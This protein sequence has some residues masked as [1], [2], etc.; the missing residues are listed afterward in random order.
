MTLQ[1]K[2][3]TTV[4]TPRSRR[5][6]FL[7]LP[8]EIR[9]LILEEVIKSAVDDANTEGPLYRMC[10]AT[11]FR[12]DCNGMMEFIRDLLW[13]LFKLR[14]L[15]PSLPE[16]RVEY[17]KA[18]Q[19]VSKQ[20]DLTETMLLRGEA[21]STSISN[22]LTPYLLINWQLNREVQAVVARSFPNGRFLEAHCCCEDAVRQT[23]AVSKVVTMAP[24]GSGGYET[25]HE[26]AAKAFGLCR[27]HL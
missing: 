12:V 23:H 1:S 13:C 9:A 27:Q 10:V 14:K 8:S 3:A 11:S 18:C 7:N 24:V 5:L 20:I 25:V 4:S 19:E 6:T 15:K 21:P 16:L 17:I 26:T 22:P 2:P